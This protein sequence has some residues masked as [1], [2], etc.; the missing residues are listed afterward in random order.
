MSEQIT[1]C[2]TDIFLPGIGNKTFLLRIYIPTLKPDGKHIRRYIH[3][4]FGIKV[5]TVWHFDLTRLPHMYVYTHTDIHTRTH[6]LVNT[7]VCFHILILSSL[8]KGVRFF[9]LFFY[10]TQKPARYLT[11]YELTSDAVDVLKHRSRLLWEKRY[12]APHDRPTI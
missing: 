3:I 12:V 7:D 8:R 1:T 11:R 6:T 2:L 4:S 10:S 9:F 5:N